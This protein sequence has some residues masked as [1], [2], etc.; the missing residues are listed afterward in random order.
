[1]QLIFKHHVHKNKDRSD[2]YRGKHKNIIVIVLKFLIKIKK[3][4][5]KIPEIMHSKN[6]TN[7]Q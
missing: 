7:C 2:I 6:L 5:I 4:F 1:M 3:S